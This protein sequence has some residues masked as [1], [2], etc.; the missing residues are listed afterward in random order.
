MFT[1]FFG[2]MWPHFYCARSWFGFAE[3]GAEA[4]ILFCRNLR[5]LCAFLGSVGLSVPLWI[6]LEGTQ[7][8]GS[9]QQQWDLGFSFFFWRI[10]SKWQLTRTEKAPE[11]PF[12]STCLLAL[13]TWKRNQT[14]D[15]LS[16]SLWGHHLFLSERSAATATRF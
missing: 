11:R 1:C 14:R 5:R 10:N 9:I 3:T 6:S 4:N 8:Q 12:L 2:E 7:Q 16:C 15:H 13:I